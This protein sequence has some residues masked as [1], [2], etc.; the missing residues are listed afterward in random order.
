MLL[1]AWT[2]SIYRTLSADASPAAVAFGIALGVVLGCVPLLSGLGLVFIAAVLVF[3]VQLSAMLLA[4]G[5]A[6]ALL[7]TGLGLLFVPVGETVLETQWLRPFWTHALN[8]PVVAWLDLDRCAVT[9]GAVVGIAMGV[10]V[11]WPVRKLVVAYRD[12]LHA[13]LSHNRFF[14][15]VTNFWFIKILRFIFIGTKVVS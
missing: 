10:V 12:F 5:L 15:T 9:G 7:A 8:L 14:T 1:L 4:L 2:R 3:R 13:P 11:F 6:K